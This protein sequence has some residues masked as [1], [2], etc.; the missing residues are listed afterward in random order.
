MC[1]GRSRWRPQGMR[2]D[3]DT[4]RSRRR[5]RRRL[6]PTHSPGS[7]ST[8][9]LAATTESKPSDQKA[10]CLKDVA[11]ATHRADALVVAVAQLVPQIP[12]VHVHEVRLHDLVVS[13]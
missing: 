3:L 5:L 6:G 13:P 7:A 10:S 2:S 4:T 12:H 8:A 11:D 1:P 9:A